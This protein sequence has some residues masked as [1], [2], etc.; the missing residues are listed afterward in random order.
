MRQAGIFCTLL[1]TMPDPITLLYLFLPL[2]I[3]TFFAFQIVLSAITQLYSLTIVFCISA[4]SLRDY[5]SPF[6]F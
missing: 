5:F 2:Y 4:P 3:F 6:G 1:L